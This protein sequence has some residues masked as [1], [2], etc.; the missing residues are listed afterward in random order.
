MSPPE[1]GG[2]VS[3]ELS[4]VG[5]DVLVSFTPSD[6]VG[7]PTGAL[8]FCS[9]VS[10]MVGVLVKVTFCS[11]NVGLAVVSFVSCKVGATVEPTPVSTGV[12]LLVVSLVCVVGVSVVSVSFK[13][14]APSVDGARVASPVTTV[15][16][17]VLKLVPAV[18]GLSV[19]FRPATGE[20]VGRPS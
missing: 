4:T 13:P 8:V 5:E 19:P 6:G 11:A 12:G 9:F 16:E 20:A 3:V 10:E 17:E 18:L 7:A 1:L 14:G 2:G 15:G